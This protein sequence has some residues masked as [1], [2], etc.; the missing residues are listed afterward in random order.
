MLKHLTKLAFVCVLVSFYSQN[1]NAQSVFADAYDPNVSFVEFGGSTNAISI[2]NVEKYTGSSSLKI[3]VPAGGYT[4]GAMVAA[5]AQN[6]S[7]YNAVTFWAKASGAKTLNVVGFGNNAATTALA[8]EWNSLAVTTSWKKFIVP[9][10]NPSKLNAETGLFHF[11]EGS[12]EGVYT[13]WLDDIKYE[14]LAAGIIGTPIPTMA[15]STVNT[16]VGATVGVNSFTVVFPVNGTNQTLNVATPNFTFLSSNAAVAS[17]SNA[18]LISALSVGTTTI[19]AKLGSINA[20]GSM[21]VNVVAATGPLVSAPTPTAPTSSVISL[22][23]NAYTNVTVDTWSAVWD[24]ADVADVLIGTTDNVKKYTGLNYAGVEFT[25]STIDATS[26]TTFHTD[27]W[28][29]DATEFKIK[30]VDFGANGS[31]GGGDDTEQELVFNSTSTPALVPNTWVSFDIPM[32]SFTGLAS[33]A[34]LAQ[35]LYIATGS[36]VFVDNVYFKGTPQPPVG[37]LTSAPLPT[38]GQSKVKSLFSNAYTNVPV[39]TWSA[40]WDQ[41]D[42]S[43]YVIGTTDS[44]KK[45]TNLAFAGVE[46]TSNTINATTMTHFHTDIWTPNA[47]EFKIKL[48]DFGANGNFG[49]GD[50]SEHEL[51]FNATSN[52]AITNSNWISFDIPLASFTGLTSRAHLAQLLFVSTNNSTVF[53]DNVYFVDQL[54]GTQQLEAVSNIFTMRPTVVSD[55]LTIFLNEQL[56]SEDASAQLSITNLVGATLVQ[57]KVGNDNITLATGSFADGIYFATVR[58]GRFIQTTKFVVQH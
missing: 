29:P 25:S 7:T 22:F 20:A 34:H 1:L 27:I 37:P 16:T 44:V 51:S 23:S 49:G 14:T 13:L 30:L 54:T 36:T 47:T 26:M 9:I 15:S 56:S 21:T 31:F 48:V 33:R 53:V 57:Q 2:D 17:V 46:F 28:T 58:K 45:Y 55:N 50:D 52:P 4:G 12:D 39:D 42:V 19:T 35:L 8:S 3:V 38:Y 40:V 10:A 32:S 6:L 18:G 11:A 43:N 24:V 41:A 5:A